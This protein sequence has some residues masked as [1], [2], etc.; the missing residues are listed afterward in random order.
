MDMFPGWAF[1]RSGGRHDAAKA[2]RSR[3]ST[4]KSGISLN[5]F[6][7]PGDDA[8]VFVDACFSYGLFRNSTLK[9]DLSNNELTRGSFV[10]VKLLN[11]RLYSLKSIRELRLSGCN[12]RCEGTQ[13]LTSWLA[14]SNTLKILDLSNNDITD[15]GDDFS[16]LQSLSRVLRTMCSLKFLNLAENELGTE[17]A[18]IFMAGLSPMSFTRKLARSHLRIDLSKND[19]FEARTSEYLGASLCNRLLTLLQFSNASVDIGENRQFGM[20]LFRDACKSGPIVA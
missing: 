9:I 1:V 13:I 2:L 14:T 3:L 15:D 7:L 17:G 18:V 10:A 19:V 5:D 6:L 11:M 12:L 20:E 16:G 8:E 4:R